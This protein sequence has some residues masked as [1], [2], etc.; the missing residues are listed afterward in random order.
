MCDFFGHTPVVVYECVSMCETM[1]DGIVGYGDV[2]YGDIEF[3]VKRIGYTFIWIT[4]FEHVQTGYE[5]VFRIV[6]SEPPILIRKYLD[7]TDRHE[8]S[9]IHTYF[10]HIEYPEYLKYDTCVRMNTNGLW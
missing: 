2:G 8:I 1:I 7:S 9:A 6:S 4:G 3:T 5:Y 10:F